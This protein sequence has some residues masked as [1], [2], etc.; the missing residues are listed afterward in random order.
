MARSGPKKTCRRC[1]TYH[2]QPGDYCKLDQTSL[3][4]GEWAETET[5]DPTR[6]AELV[7]QRSREQEARENLNTLNRRPDVYKLITYPFPM[8]DGTMAYLNLPENIS[9]KDVA[10]LQRMLETLPFEK[11]V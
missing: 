10:R 5:G 7:L 6:A 9:K 11:E 2:W 3:D 8:S 4:K 1:G